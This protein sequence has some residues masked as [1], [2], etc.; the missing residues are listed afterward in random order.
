MSLTT[1]SHTKGTTHTD[2]GIEGFKPKNVRAQAKRGIDG[3]KSADNHKGLHVRSQS[4][5]YEMSL[6]TQRIAAEQAQAGYAQHTIRGSF[7]YSCVVVGAMD[8]PTD[9]ITDTTS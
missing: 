2:T 8:T 5:S 7:K 9:T 1:Q 3:V 6:Q 4:I